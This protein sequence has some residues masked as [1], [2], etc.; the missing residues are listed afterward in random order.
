M[1]KFLVFNHVSYIWQLSQLVNHQ[2]K[3]D[4]VLKTPRRSN[5][6]YGIWDLKFWAKFG[7][8]FGPFWGFC[9]YFHEKKK[10][11]NKSKK[12]VVATLLN[13]KYISRYERAK[14]YQRYVHDTCIVYVQIV[15]AV[16]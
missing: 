16:P 5:T 7:T 4:S 12:R 10:K 3:Q 8:I 9:R 1:H 13:S 2:L 15:I 11:C 14:E 6:E